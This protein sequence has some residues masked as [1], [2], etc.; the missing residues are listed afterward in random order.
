MITAIILTRNE[1]ANIKECIQSLTWCEEIL[2][3]DDDST[4]KTVEIAKSLNAT[5]YTRSLEKDFAQQRNFGLEKA[6]G[7]WVFFIDADER[8]SF[9][10]SYEIQQSI[11]QSFTRFNG[12]YIPR[13]DYLWGRKMLHGEAGHMKL[14]RL[15]KKNS[16]QFSGTVHEEWKV[17]GQI[18]ELK[19]A[20]EH[21]PHPTIA[22]FLEE[23]NYYTDIRAQELYQKDVT[24][25]WW[26]ILIYP[27]AKFLKNFFIK[28]GF[29]D[30]I[31]GLIHA[32]IMSFH[33]F[34][35]RAKLWLIIQKEK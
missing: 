10:L 20:I 8:V 21:F 3:I 26:S 22:S 15:A 7:E 19:N 27:T 18:G 5:I 30:G 14:L 32:I 34:L 31:P 29:L 12:Y 35:V 16:G 25:T 1:E 6:H 17:K 9:T 4:D 13:I 28:L 2:V 11:N 33:S 24:A 23:I